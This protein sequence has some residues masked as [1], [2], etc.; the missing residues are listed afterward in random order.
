MQALTYSTSAEAALR[1]I[2]EVTGAHTEW[3]LSADTGSSQT[4]LKRDEFDFSVSSRALILSCWTER[5]TATWRVRAWEWT[6]DKL[7]LEATRRMGA[8]RALL[9]LIP[10]ASAKAITATVT[11]ARVVRSEKMARAALEMLPGS[12]VERAALSPGMRRGQPGRYARIIL[13]TPQKRIAVTGTVALG[14]PRNID[15]LLSSALLWLTRLSQRV[16]PPYIKELWL[17]V[18]P[19]SREA[20]RERLTLLRDDFRRLITI[21]EIDDVW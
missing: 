7:R 18:E 21:Y 4:L 8:E 11:A 17:V 16:R 5:G 6:S 3:L 15:S 13:R 19:S 14:D 2:K 12:K 10:R 1:A 20:A 9:E